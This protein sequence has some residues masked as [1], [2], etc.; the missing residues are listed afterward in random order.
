[1][2][3]RLA[4]A[5]AR[6]GFAFDWAS[7]R[8]TETNAEAAMGSGVAGSD[9]RVDVDG[10]VGRIVEREGGARA[11]VVELVVKHRG[12]GGLGLYRTSAMG[13]PANRQCGHG[14]QDFAQMWKFGHAE[15]LG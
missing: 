8:R 6:A 2:Q 11:D 1:M 12:T 7:E 14:Y 15:L 13:P 9:S 3:N 10:V 4:E 5:T